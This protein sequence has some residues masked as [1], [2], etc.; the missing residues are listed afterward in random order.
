MLLRYKALFPGR[1]PRTLNPIENRSESPVGYSFPGDVNETNIRGSCK[2]AIV[3]NSK[4][5]PINEIK[6]FDR[7]NNGSAH[8]RVA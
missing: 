2:L 8:H 4:T 6:G 7:S 3:S 1:T 5:L